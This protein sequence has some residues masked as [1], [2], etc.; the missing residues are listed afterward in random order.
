MANHFLS[1]F[2]T[3]YNSGMVTKWSR[4]RADLT[5]CAENW[6]FFRPSFVSGE[7]FPIFKA[8]QLPPALL[9][10][11]TSRTKIDKPVLEDSARYSFERLVHAPVKFNLLLQSAQD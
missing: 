3:D 8:Y 6:I 11:R 10:L 9:D 1:T 7:T 2:S 5:I 4:V